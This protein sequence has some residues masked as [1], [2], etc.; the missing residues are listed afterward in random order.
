MVSGNFKIESK[1]VALDNNPNIIM[2]IPRQMKSS[3]FHVPNVKSFMFCAAV[4]RQYFVSQLRF[5]YIWF[6]L[7]L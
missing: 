2:R 6:I 5:S 3:F 4:G 7:K 1:V